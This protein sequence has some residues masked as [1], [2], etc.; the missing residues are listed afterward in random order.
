MAFADIRIIIR[1]RRKPQYF[2]RI[3]T[4]RELSDLKG[5]RIRFS[6]KRTKTIRSIF[7]PI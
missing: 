5:I 3:R 1:I 2:I 4:I 6:P 7:I